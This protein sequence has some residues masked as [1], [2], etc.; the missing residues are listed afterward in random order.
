VCALQDTISCWPGPSSE[1]SHLRHY[2]KLSPQLPWRA[3][4]ARPGPKQ[5]RPLGSRLSAATRSGWMAR[6]FASWGST[7]PRLASAPDATLSGG[8]A[9]LRN[10]GSGLS[11]PK[12]IWIFGS[13]IVRLDP[14][15]TK[16]SA[17]RHYGRKAPMWPGS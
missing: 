7:P 13:A 4:L 12:A 5:S 9:R 17:A 1:T 15:T 6:L 8:P 2:R 16:A 3:S 10:G 14:V 11:S